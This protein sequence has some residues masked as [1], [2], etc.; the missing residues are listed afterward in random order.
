MKEQLVIQYAANQHAS[1]IIA[2]ISMHVMTFFKQYHFR[3]YSMYGHVEKLAEEIKKVADSMEGVEDTLWRVW[4]LKWTFP[5]YNIY[6]KV[7]ENKHQKVYK[8]TILEGS[9]ANKTTLVYFIRS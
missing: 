1:S 2:A 5:F 4:I 8:P 3:Y 6:N 7:Y 9:K